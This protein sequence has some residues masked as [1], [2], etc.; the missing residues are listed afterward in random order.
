M[1]SKTK[2]IKALAKYLTENAAM[3]SVQLQIN[4]NDHW[5]KEWAELRE[6]SNLFGW[7]SKDEAE[8]QLTELLK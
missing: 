2:F 8:K 5:P 4:P 7:V 1:N 6:N 3:A